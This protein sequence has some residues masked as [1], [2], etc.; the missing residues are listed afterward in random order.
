MFIKSWLKYNIQ[1]IIWSRY[2]Y[3]LSAHHVSH[4]HFKSYIRYHYET[5][6]TPLQPPKT[7]N[8]A[9]IL[10]IILNCKNVFKK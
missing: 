4:N 2:I 8:K 7:T 5:K 3:K 9:N 10:L 1:Y 6:S